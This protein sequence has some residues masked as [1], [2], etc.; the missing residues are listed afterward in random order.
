MQTTKAPIRIGASGPIGVTEAGH[1]DLQPKLQAEL[2][3]VSMGVSGK[4]DVYFDSDGA[5]SAAADTLAT[6]SFD[7]VTGPIQLG[8][9]FRMPFSLVGGHDLLAIKSWLERARTGLSAPE[10][11]TEL[12]WTATPNAQI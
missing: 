3:S 2:P 7:D 9:G 12:V 8:E 6:A 5:S 4:A 1:I 11:G 10:G